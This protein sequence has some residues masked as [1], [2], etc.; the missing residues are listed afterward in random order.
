MD[1]ISRYT[2]VTTIQWLYLFVQKTMEYKNH[3]SLERVKDGKHV[4][5]CDS[6]WTKAKKSE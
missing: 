4:L 6:W 3:K 1:N 2:I 5:E